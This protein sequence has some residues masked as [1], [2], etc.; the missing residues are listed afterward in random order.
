MAVIVRRS[1]SS[2]SAPGTKVVAKATR[3]P[4]GGESSGLGRRM[5]PTK[6]MKYAGIASA[7]ATRKE[8]TRKRGTETTCE[9]CSHQAQK[10]T[11]AQS[12]SSARPRYTWRSDG[13]ITGT[14]VWRSGLGG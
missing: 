3:R 8:V 1:T 4:A 12:Q 14:V 2:D 7:Y 13:A 10:A 5:R 6:N 9:G 11:V